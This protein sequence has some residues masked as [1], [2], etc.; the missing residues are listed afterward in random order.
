ME[1]KLYCTLQVHNAV[2]VSAVEFPELLEFFFSGDVHLHSV[3]TEAQTI[4]ND[5]NKCIMNG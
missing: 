1:I 4:S 3:F 2:V 5:L